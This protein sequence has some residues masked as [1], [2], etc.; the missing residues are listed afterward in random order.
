MKELR[1][2]KAAFNDVKT[3]KLFANKINKQFNET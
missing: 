1:S 2:I 3:Q